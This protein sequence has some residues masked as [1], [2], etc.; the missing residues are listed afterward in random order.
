MAYSTSNKAGQVVQNILN[1][2]PGL[3]AVAI[4]DIESGMASASHSNS[5]TF[6]PETAAAYNTEVVRQK[7]KAMSA[8]KLTNETIEDVLITLTTQLHL[9]KLA[10][11]GKQFIYL[12]VNSREINLAIARAV[13][14]EHAEGLE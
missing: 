5:P 2:L 12:A 13:L 11:G 7:R 3:I 14:R 4:V 9:I 8:L 6:N 10:K 1:D